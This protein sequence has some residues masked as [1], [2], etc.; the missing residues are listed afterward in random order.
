MV[1]IGVFLDRDGTINHTIK[2]INNVSELKI[3][4]FAFSAVKLLNK[5]KL[6]V[7]I[8]TN[9]GGVSLGYMKEE[10]LT[11]IH[12]KLVY[13]FKKHGAYFDD[14]FVSTWHK[15]KVQGVL[16][17]PSNYRKP[18][19]GMLEVAKKLYGIDLKKSFVIGDRLSDVQTA[20][21]AGGTG[22]LVLTG[23]GR[24]QAELIKAKNIIPDFIFENLYEAV[25]NILQLLM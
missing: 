5:H 21:N 2:P 8:V 14:I 15:R 24:D 17:T 19:I 11:E 18:G 23:N 16:S 10:T 9:Q 7:F 25:L 4:P 3:Y 12:D 6:P 13:E 20:K 22:I 1:K